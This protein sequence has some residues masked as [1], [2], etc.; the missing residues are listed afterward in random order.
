MMTLM[1]K[2]EEKTRLQ[3]IK[4]ASFGIPDNEEYSVIQAQLT[5]MA[6]LIAEMKLTGFLQRITRAHSTGPIFNPTLYRNAMDGLDKVER[7]ARA[8]A[9]FQAVVHKIMMDET[10]EQQ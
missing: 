8:A 2:V 9:A 1:D 4:G 6:G 3:A 7:L 5:L 10:R